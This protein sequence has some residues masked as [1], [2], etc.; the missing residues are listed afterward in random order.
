MNNAQFDIM[1]DDLHSNAQTARAMGAQLDN[2]HETGSRVWHAL[3]DRL[4]EALDQTDNMGK[5][6]TPIKP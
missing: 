6:I 1:R 5:V 2:V 4:F 3:A